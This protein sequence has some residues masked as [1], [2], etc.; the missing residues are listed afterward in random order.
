MRNIAATLFL[1]ALA[2]AGFGQSPWGIQASSF[3]GIYS[4]QL[5]PANLADNRISTELHLGGGSVDFWNNY[6]KINSSLLTSQS[7]WDDLADSPDGKS[8]FPDDLDGNRKNLFINAT[9]WGPGFMQSFKNGLGFSLTSRFR[10]LSS[11]SNMGE[12][13]AKQSY[14]EQLYA[15]YHNVREDASGSS[16]NAA[17]FLELGAGLGITL[18]DKGDRYLKAGVNVKYLTGFAGVSLHA[19]NGSYEFHDDSL[20]SAYDADV[21]YAHSDA[22]LDFADSDPFDFL[23][24]GDNG[25]AFDLGV[26]YEFRPEAD[27]H[28]YGKGKYRK[29][30]AD[31][32]AYKG[33][34]GISLLDIGG[35]NFGRNQLSQNFFGNVD[36]INLDLEDIEDVEQFDQF[37]NRN[38]AT[39]PGADNFTMRLP[40]RLSIQGDYKFTD[41]LA[42]TG[43][44][45]LGP[46]APSFRRIIAQNSFVL[47]PRY[48]TKWLGFS[49]PVTWQ[50][51]RSLN[52]GASVRLGP[53][54][55][56]SNNI[57]NALVQDFSSTASVYAGLRVALPHGKPKDTDHDGVPNRFDKCKRDSGLVALEGCPE[58]DSLKVDDVE[59]L[60]QTDEE[61]VEVEPEPEPELEP[62]PEPEPQPEPEPE[63][64]PQ[65]E[66]E[67]EPA[68]SEAEGSGAEG[69]LPVA[70]EKLT[71]LEAYLPYT[72]RDGDGVPNAEDACPDV[73]GVARNEGC[74]ELGVGKYHYR[75]NIYTSL[76]FDSDKYVIR[77]RGKEILSKLEDLMKANPN[78][79]LILDGHTDNSGA[80][81]Y[82]TDLSLNRAM[83][84]LRF[85]AFRGID[86]DRIEV[87]H[88][89]ERFPAATNDTS[90]GMQL[91]RRVDIT[92]IK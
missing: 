88:Y 38:F 34:I 73:P 23:F 31:K 80:E 16:I 17:S 54:F 30:R 55:V 43:I 48:D 4:A 28:K 76:Y 85:L 19:W 84:V 41:K 74:P 2:Y 69:P 25:L 6:I 14:D 9:A 75:S 1:V 36:S 58:T 3:G 26:V 90:Q 22:V 59:E 82:N 89:G 47:V 5:N 71:G 86:I 61:E 57:V 44:L 60:A 39:Q 49:L 51:F 10:S 70:K 79:R 7:A 67:P 53:V 63:P 56:G 15:P 77:R 27:K 62:E 68:L 64:E 40:T 66:P 33:R 52:V 78:A 29:K 11:L 92:I 32:D 20:F 8:F 45:Q 42:A 87:G 12:V 50:S 65:S 21:S 37:F 72:D 24:G 13:F 46:G 81:I 18:F 83:A 35:I 91:N